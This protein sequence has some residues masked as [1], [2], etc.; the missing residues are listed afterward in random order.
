MTKDYEDVL[1]NNSSYVGDDG[2]ETPELGELPEEETNE[3][4]DDE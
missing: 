2:R 1:L 4:Q 3:D